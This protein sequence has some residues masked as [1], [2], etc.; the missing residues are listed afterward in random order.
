MVIESSTSSESSEKIKIGVVGDYSDNYFK[1][2]IT[3]LENLDTSRLSIDL[4]RCNS[5]DDAKVKLSNDT[6]SAYVLVPEGFVV[7]A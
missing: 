3:A 6:I 2:G 7:C 4:V 1:T 5:E